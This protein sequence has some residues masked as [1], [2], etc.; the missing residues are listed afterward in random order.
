MK[1]KITSLVLL[2]IFFM[3]FTISAQKSS[4]PDSLK[5]ISLAGL[6][7]RSIGPAITGGRISAIA[8]NPDNHSEYYVASGH[9][10]LWKTT[11]KG[12]TFDPVFDNQDSYAI[13]SVAIDPT[14]TN[15]VWVGTGENNNQNNVIY[16]DGIYKSEDGGKSWKNMGLKESEHIGG[17]EIDPNNSNIVYA[18]AYG[19]LRNPGGDRGIYKTT[20]GGKTWER[21]LFIS[22]NTGCFQVHM[23][24]RYSNILYAVA[25]QRM[26][27]LYTGVYGGP[28]SG[29][30]RTTD[31]GANWDKMKSGLPSED[32]GRVGMDIS[33]V[34]PDILY[35]VVEADKENLGFY[36]SI[37]RGVSW[38]KQSNYN[39]AYKF[40]FQKIVADTKDA[41]RVYSM[42]VFMKFTDDGGKTFE[43]VGSKFK[44]VDDHCMWVN[45]VDN[46]HLIAGCDGGVYESYD[47]GKN[48]DFKANLPITE[49]Y[50]VATDNAKPFY[51]VF[52]GTQDNN[53]LT[54]PSRTISSGGIT[55]Q[56]WLFTN[57]GDGFE[58]QVDWKDPN[59]IY[60]MSQNGGLVRFDKKSG[61]NYYIKPYEI[62]DT[63][64]RFD[65]DAAL[66]IS[67][68]DNK[69]L[70]FG[71]NKLL[72]T[73]DQGSTWKEISPDLTRGVPKEMQKLMGQSWSI[74]QLAAK[75]SMANIV[76]I[77]ESPLDEKILFVG[78]GDGLI[79][80]TTNSGDKWIKSDVPGIP[81]YARIHHI[82]ASNFDKKTAYAA[83]HNFIGGDKLP[84][85]Y[86]TTDGG[87]NWFSINSN[88]PKRGSTYT[89]AEDHVERNLLFVGT[90]FGVYFSN[91]GGDEWI[92]LKN[93]IPNH[94]VMD[95]EI[96]RDEN[97]LVVS[98]FGRGVY[99]LDDYS[100]LR[101]L[102]NETLKKEAMIFPI[103][104]A[105]MFIPS[106]PFGFKGIGFM[107]A[108]F[109]SSPN[110]EIGAV[111]TYY[112]K[113]GF[114]TL[115]EKRREEE[116]ELVKKGKDIKYPTYET[117][118][119][120]SEEQD[121]YLLFTVMDMQNNVVRK[122]KTSPSKGVNR[123]VWDFRYSPF[124]PIDLTP[125]D[126]SVPWMSEDQGYMV[127]PGKYQVTL[128]KFD[129]GKFTDIA[130]P[131]EFI[132]KPLNNT[133]LPAPD[134]IELDKFNE[135]VAEL[136]RAIS[137]ADAYRKEL[138]KKISYLKKAVVVASDVPAETFNNIVRVEL[139]LEKFNR[140][141]NGD[142]LRAKYEGAS[143]TSVRDRV[144]LI[145]YALWGTTGAATSTLKRA[146]EEASNKFDDLLVSLKSIDTNINGIESNLEKLG[147]PHTPGRFP[148]WNNK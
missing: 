13:G 128:S 107:G 69:R 30:Y 62:G 99:I 70:Y 65:W 38:T 4:E 142:N 85:L 73:D 52:I 55:N 83:I 75:S 2:F 82:I 114:K 53:S 57:G 1:R 58:S 124:T 98:T 118:R 123:V 76:T 101:Q 44:H 84:Y 80:Y 135:K 50:K 117:L 18:A 133:T 71:A 5:N 136:T 86:K 15:I 132:C 78:S 32:I 143:P 31:S 12:I 72:R 29:I 137:G 109:Y 23:D 91:N 40:Y 88:L 8:V 63:A 14:N 34:N 125:F 9:G 41:D 111:F 147:A 141:L 106:N 126:D 112:L 97:D 6:K 66:L 120:E 93:G 104:D 59:I 19:S 139:E 105:L 60:A 144:G 145:T 47:K 10:N 116:K 138:V 26:R 121:S 96:Q 43:N 89:V 134:K 74:D 64:Y 77:A 27:N 103:E 92:K 67:K 115:K 22:E 24:P 122:I 95:I 36:R 51:N 130:G 131:A 140:D 110:P 37:D 54:G 33:P 81:K 35:A 28:E 49:I 11:N 119:K 21:S 46:K 3:S 20:D 16:G 94:S 113:D 146:Y 39:S 79:H 100:P 129:E 68:H 90:Q 45:P 87:A 48:W 56:D 61:E 108:S 102:S 127:V 42:D 17:I 25:H 7:F 148:I